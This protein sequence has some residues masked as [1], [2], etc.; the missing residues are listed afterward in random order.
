MSDTKKTYERTEIQAA[1]EPVVA[2]KL[3]ELGIP[4]GGLDMDHTRRTARSLI[5]MAAKLC[6]EKGCPPQAFLALAMEC[7]MKEAGVSSP[8]EL[9]AVAMAK[10]KSGGTAN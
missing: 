9:M 2:A 6:I 8:E 3:A 5:R 1:L 10:A 7:F 4:M